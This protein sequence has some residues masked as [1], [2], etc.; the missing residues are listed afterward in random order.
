M[1]DKNQPITESNS[2]ETAEGSQVSGIVTDSSSTQA[3][4]TGSMDTG[5]VSPDAPKLPGSDQKE[6]LPHRLLDK[7][8]LYFVLL[9]V[10]LLGLAGISYYAIIQNHKNSKANTLNTQKLN[11]DALDKLASTDSSVGDPKQ[12]L[13][14]ESNAIF[15]GGVII[16]GNIDIAGTLK[17]GGPLSLPGLTVGGTTSLDQAAVKSLTDSGDASFQGK[18]TIQNGISVT[19]GAS[20]S[21]NVTAPQ[22]SA[23]SL[24][25]GKELQLNSHI[26][27]SGATPSHANG[28]ALGSGGTAS[29]S[30]TDTSG[31]VVINTGGGAP[32]GC[33]VT[34]TFTR[35]YA[36]VPH[37][38]LSPASSTAGGMAYYV[39]RSASNFSICTSAD[40]P[41][42]TSA[43][44][45][46][47]IVVG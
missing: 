28:S 5:V 7:L 12:T 6:S 42:N 47:Y 11:Q 41:D 9:I 26:V 13:S 40:A 8:N 45:F 17:V 34:I 3:S 29:N 23:D 21:G 2:L 32:A 18:V 35:A 31:T 36:S 37:V 46:D 39:N 22:I 30:G 33:F 38:I 14:I 15:T 1:D 43:I 19:G 25:L 44:T 24:L 10:V 20:F 4:P 27:S 16:R